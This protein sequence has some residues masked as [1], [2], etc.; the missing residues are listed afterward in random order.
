[1]CSPSFTFCP[2]ETQSWQCYLDRTQALGLGS[3]A[4]EMPSRQ[5]TQFVVHSSAAPAVMWQ[6]LPVPQAG[7]GSRMIA[8]HRRWSCATAETPLF[9]RAALQ[10]RSASHCTAFRRAEFAIMLG[11]PLVCTIVQSF[12]I[13][14]DKEQSLPQQA[15]VLLGWACFHSVCVLLICPIR[16]CLLP[17]NG[18]LRNITPGTNS[19]DPPLPQA[20]APTKLTIL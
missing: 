18:R 9:R 20:Q 12:R 16:C 4:Q 3:G 13:F 14:F 15:W 19:N 7:K 10:C 8:I 2:S 17:N 1:M 6:M 11:R 5:L